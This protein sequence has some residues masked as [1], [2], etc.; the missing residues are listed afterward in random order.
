MTPTNASLGSLDPAKQS[1]L[2]ATGRLIGGDKPTKEAYLH[3]VMYAKRSGV[4]AVVHLHS[5]YSV[6]HDLW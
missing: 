6:R 3:Q 4:Q 1:R 2:D 5:T